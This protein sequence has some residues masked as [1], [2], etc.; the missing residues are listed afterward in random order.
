M[1]YTNS[2]IRGNGSGCILWF[3][4]LVDIR[5]YTEDGQDLY[6]RM[7]SSEIGKYKH[8]LTC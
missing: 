3:G 1:A 5:Q 8:I 4:D 2:D 6:I 7:A